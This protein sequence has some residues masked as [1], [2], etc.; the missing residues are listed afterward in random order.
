VRY[1]IRL[2]HSQKWGSA[3][4]GTLYPHGSPLRA[5]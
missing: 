4:N 3:I 2:H 5:G 1:I